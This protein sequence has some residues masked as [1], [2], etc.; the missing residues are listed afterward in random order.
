VIFVETPTFTRRVLRLLDDKNY[1][2]LQTHLTK[3]PDAGDVIRGGGGLRKIR[4]AAKG[5]G[6]RGGVRVIYYWWIAKDRISML[7]IYPKNEMDDLSAEQLKLLRQT[8][9]L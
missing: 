5:R 6:K 4:W 7:F 3:H 1:G 8:L 2:A 9:E